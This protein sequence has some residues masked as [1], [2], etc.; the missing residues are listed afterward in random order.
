MALGCRAGFRL[1]RTYIVN[2]K[3]NTIRLIIS[4][5]APPSENNTELYIRKVVELT[6]IPENMVISFYD[7]EIMIGL[8]DAMCMM[9]VGQKISRYVV[10]YGYTL[11]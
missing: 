10:N 9:E 7:R 3:L 8:F 5:W 2:R 6:G 11:V 1:L 4:R